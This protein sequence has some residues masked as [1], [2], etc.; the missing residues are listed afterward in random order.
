MLELPE[1]DQRLEMQQLQLAIEK[2]SKCQSL[3]ENGEAVGENYK[4]YQ[5]YLQDT[6]NAA[7]FSNF[8]PV[9]SIRN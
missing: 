8:E 3:S 2:S 1:A 9:E 5:D 7:F 6:R 4:N